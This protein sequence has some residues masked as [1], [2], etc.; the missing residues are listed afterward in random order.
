MQLIWQC[1]YRDDWGCS[2]QLS[3]VGQLLHVVAYWMLR[4]DVQFHTCISPKVQW[5][6]CHNQVVF[7]LA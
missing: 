1:V 7:S 4:V 5:I 6:I 3:L 2:S